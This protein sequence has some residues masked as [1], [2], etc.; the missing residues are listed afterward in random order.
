MAAQRSLAAAARP[1]GSG[2]SRA[3]ARTEAGSTSEVLLFMG[4]PG[5][6]KGT[7]ASMVA[8]E[9]SLAKLSTGDMLRAHVR[10]GTDLGKRAKVLMD[11]GVLVPDELIIAMVRS[12]LEE[13]EPVRV[14]LDGFPRTTAQAE[15]LDRL[16]DELGAPITAAIELKVDAEELVAR[17]LKRA[18]QEGRSDDNEDTIR[19]RMR[20]YT[21]QT[22]PLL[23]YYRRAG[24][25][26][27]VDGV[28]TLDE[29]SAR[30]Q[31]AI[32]AATE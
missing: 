15:A 11:E 28:G 5:A 14:L 23:D 2:S 21:E 25:L 32:E 1:D 27:Q 26:E 4:P 30:I 20:V 19:T 31:D 17:L 3:T 13:M 18:E 9:R 29:V 22:A 24:K 12:E 7:Q 16:L 6:G 8:E 10:S